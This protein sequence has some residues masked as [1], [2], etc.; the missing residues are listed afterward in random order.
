[1]FIN[2]VDNVLLSCGKN[3]TV[4]ILTKHCIIDLNVFMI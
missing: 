3:V 2:H 4:L 1:M